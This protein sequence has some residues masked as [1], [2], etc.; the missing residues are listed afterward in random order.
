MN[1]EFTIQWYPGHMAKARRQL[2]S[3]IRQ[4]D[5]V[6]EVADA[7]APAT[8]RNPDIDELIQGRPRLLLLSK[9]DLAEPEALSHWRRRWEAE[10]L[11]VIAASFVQQAS[12]NRA[13]T[14]ILRWLDGVKDP[15]RASP[16]GLEHVP[17]LRLPRS[18]TR[19]PVRRGLVVGLPN[20][21]KSTFIRA[22]GGRG[23][24]V[25]AVAGVT[26]SLQW[27]NAG[28][29]V[30][31]LDSPGLLWP[32]AE[33]G[34]A[35]L[36]LAWLGLVGDAAYDPVEAGLGL[37]AWLISQRPDVLRERYDLQGWQPLAGPESE[38]KD[39]AARILEA[40][41]K[42]RGLLWR[43]GEPDLK[44][45]AQALLWDLRRGRLG[46]VTFDDPLAG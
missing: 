17:G 37:A 25:G 3:Q 23:V 2:V 8:S 46:K 13:K 36:V 19:A 28:A 18:S 11:E 30:Q 42:E 12:V 24:A 14:R 44:Q 6:I 1:Q 41:A 35:A 15:G 29:G 10:G 20:T 33:S 9:E 5:F 40:V 16:A 31:L 4:V 26:R 32:R 7:R 21:G 39:M 27:V 43:G 34:E 45:A 22:M 38:T